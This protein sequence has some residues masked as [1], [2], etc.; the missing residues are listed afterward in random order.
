MANIL[1]NGIKY[2]PAGGQLSVSVT[3]M[4]AYIKVDIAD[5]GKGIPEDRQG[6]VF[7]RFYRNRKYTMFRE[8]AWA[9]IWPARSFRT[10][11]GLSDYIKAGIQDNI[12][13][14]FI[15]AHVT[16]P[17]GLP[18]IIGSSGKIIFRTQQL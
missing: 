2:T 7:K 14:I 9:F 8:L 3:A 4:E 1:D 6:A 13:S 10:R 16:I 12:F 17:R 11:E 15:K 5:T 18:C